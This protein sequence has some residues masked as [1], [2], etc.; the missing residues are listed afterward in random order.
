[1][2]AWQEMLNH[3]FITICLPKMLPC[4]EAKLQ[5]LFGLLSLSKGC[6]YFCFQ[7]AEGLGA[8]ARLW[9]EQTW[10]SRRANTDPGRQP[11]IRQS[12][13]SQEEQR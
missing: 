10:L 9:W 4:L 8:S 1:M 7:L 6:R 5:I 12:F 13:W 3:L 2:S 11:F